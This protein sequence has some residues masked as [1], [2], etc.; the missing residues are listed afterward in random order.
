VAVGQRPV[1]QPLSALEHDPDPVVGPEPG[2]LNREQVA[3]PQLE[4]GEGL[5][6]SLAAG[7]ATREPA[8]QSARD[9]R[10]HNE[11][12]DRNREA[13]PRSTRSRTLVGVH[14]T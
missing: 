8:R 9:R 3:A 13:N 4:R 7:V 14:L 10:K 11:S 2:A 12:G 6:R 5:A 1:N